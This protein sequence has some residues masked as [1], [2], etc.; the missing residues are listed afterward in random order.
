MTSS[1][2]YQTRVQFIKYNDDVKIEFFPGGYVIL[3]SIKI[4]NSGH[5]HKETAPAVGGEPESAFDQAIVWTIHSTNPTDLPPKQ[6]KNSVPIQWGDVIVL[7][8]KGFTDHLLYANTQSIFLNCGTVTIHKTDH[9][10]TRAHWTIHPVSPGPANPVFVSYGDPIVLHSVAEDGNQLCFV[11]A[12]DRTYC[13]GT[14]GDKGTFN[15]RPSVCVNPGGYLKMLSP[16]K[17]HDLTKVA[18]CTVCEETGCMK[19][20]GADGVYMCSVNM[21]WPGHKYVIPQRAISGKQVICRCPGKQ[22]PCN[23]PQIPCPKPNQLCVKGK[24]VVPDCTQKNHCPQ[25]KDCVNNTC[26]TP[27]SNQESEAVEFVAIAVIALVV[28]AIIYYAYKESR[29]SKAETEEQL[30]KS[31]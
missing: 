29:K 3:G 8:R 1:P 22:E 14:T 12:G 23:P 27:K 28:G 31:L 19:V 4:F 7:Q 21:N 17:G 13:W 20:P 30:F 2:A 24:C 16:S 6:Y 18:E 25:G 15:T 26:V 5:N 10:E 11:S 9:T